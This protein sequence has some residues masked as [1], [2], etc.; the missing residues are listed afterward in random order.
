MLNLFYLVAIHYSKQTKNYKVIQLRY[1]SSKK[2][3][4]ITTL[5][6]KSLRKKVQ[7]VE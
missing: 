1:Y 6:L 4:G 3:S 2:V 7:N 5:A